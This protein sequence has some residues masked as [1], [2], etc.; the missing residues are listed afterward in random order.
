MDIS[1][2]RDLDRYERMPVDM[3]GEAMLM[4]MGWNPEDGKIGKSNAS[5]AHSSCFS[6]HL[7]LF[8]VLVVLSPSLPRHVVTIRVWEPMSR[9]RRTGATRSLSSQ[10]KSAMSRT[11]YAISRSTLRIYHV[12]SSHYHFIS[13]F[14]FDTITLF[15]FSME[16]PLFLTF[17]LF[18]F[19]VLVVQERT[20]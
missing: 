8:V 11:R 5:Y 16:S 3:F 14:V 7:L 4:G 18:L 20:G 12:Y 10:G 17:I 6:S 15:V 9:N 19:C 1:N 2:P 13:I